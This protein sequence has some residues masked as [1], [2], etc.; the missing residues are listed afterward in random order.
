MINNYKELSI[1]KFNQLKEIETIGREEID[2]Q[3]EILSILSDIPEEEILD[4][5]FAKYQSLVAQSKFLTSPPPITKK[6]PK[7]IKLGDK[8]Y[9]VMTDINKFTAGQY[10]DYQTYIG[11]NADNK[12][13][14]YILTC[15][16]I[17][18]GM[19]YGSYDIEAVIEDFNKHLDIATALSISAFFLRKWERLT[20][21]MLIYLVWKMKRAMKKEKNPQMR[22]K[23]KEAINQLTTLKNLVKDGDGSIW[24]L[25]LKK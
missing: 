25:G 5:P 6:C 15:F 13:F 1:L 11:L 7:T 22:E 23:M 14:S 10:I 24:Q 19:K 3:V 20:R 17:P 21:G 2:I 12:Y 9:D 18:K 8:E 16:I 4:L